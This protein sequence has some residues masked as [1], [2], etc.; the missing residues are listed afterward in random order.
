MDD[1]SLYTSISLREESIQKVKNALKLLKSKQIEL[2]E[3][4][5]MRECLRYVLRAWKG[6]KT[7][8]ERLRT[9]NQR[10]GIYKIK[11]FYLPLK[12]YQVTWAR[13][14]HSGISVSRMVDFGIT[15]YLDRIVEEYLATAYR[16]REK[17]DVEKWQKKVEARRGISGFLINYSTATAKN[18]GTVLDYLETT[19]IMSHQ[20]ILRRILPP[21]H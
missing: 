4:R 3:Q 16:G 8:S 20:A 1:D 11:A 7:K 9:Y 13:S 2:S 18:D 19:E 15:T 21:R 5:L 17:V 12:L 14:H 10:S 6:R